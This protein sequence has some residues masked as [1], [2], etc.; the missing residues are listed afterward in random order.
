[1]EIKLR[2]NLQFI[3]DTLLTGKTSLL[4][5][6]IDAYQPDT[7]GVLTYEDSTLRTGFKGVKGL[8][9]I[10]GDNVSDTVIVLPPF[11]FCEEG[12]S[13][14]FFDPELPRLFTDSYCCH[15]DNLFSI[16]DID[17]DGASEICIYMSSCASRFKSL[18]AFSLKGGRWKEIGRCTYDIAFVEPDKIKRVRKINK[19]RFEMLE[20]VDKEESNKWL[21]FSF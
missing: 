18:V 15:P 19:G 13:Y 5:K 12:D 16:S 3:G 17:E 9:D 6:Y 21:Q 14:Y 4:Q 8:G 7:C 1:M 20:I 11:N 2:Q 10:N